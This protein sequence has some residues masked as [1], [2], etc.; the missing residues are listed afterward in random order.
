MA[1]YNVI[2][3]PNG[4]NKFNNAHIVA[5]I[6]AR[7]SLH[8]SYMHTFGMTEN[9]FIIVEQPLG[10]SMMESV[11]ARVLQKP[12]VSTLKWFQDEC[13]LIHAVCRHSGRRKF[14][15]SAAAFFFLHVINAYE[16]DDHIVVDICC[17]RDPSVLDCMYIDAMENM[18]Q[19][20][21][22]ANMFRSRPLRFVLPIN[23]PCTESYDDESM[24]LPWNYCNWITYLTRT[25]GLEKP[26]GSMANINQVFDEEGATIESEHGIGY[27]NENLVELKN[28]T[29]KAYR[30]PSL[31]DGNDP[32]IFCVPE[33]LCD[34]GC[35]T[36]RINEKR[37]QGTW[38]ASNV[39]VASYQMTSFF[40]GRV[41]RY[42][43]A[44]SSDVDALIPGT[45]I[46]SAAKFDPIHIL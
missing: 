43:Y 4:P 25:P 2:C 33:S 24:S 45:V 23:V 37:S 21:N 46:T 9:Y 5:S 15:F 26:Y 29:A 27:G 31:H 11:K 39:A 35:E 34:I 40:P 3:F 20:M 17:Y 10:I 1:A 44:I 18:Q 41:Y 19:I 14:T 8:P 13:T 7:W 42:F 30:M 38:R 22:Y 16:T 12:L 28:S 32:V 6:P 36:P